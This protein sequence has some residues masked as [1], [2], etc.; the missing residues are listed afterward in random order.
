[1]L[2]TTLLLLDQEGVVALATYVLVAALTIGLIHWLRVLI[3]RLEAA[4]NR[5]QLLVSELQHRS[6]NLFTVIQSIA[7]RSLVDGQPL[8][9]AREVF[10]SRLHALARAHRMLAEAAWT[11]A[12]LVQIL[13]EELASVSNSVTVNGC[14]IVINTPAA[15]H[16]AMIVHELATNALKYGALSLPGGRIRIEGSTEQINGAPVL[17]PSRKGFGT[18]I[19]IDAAKQVAQNVSVNYDPNGLR[20]ELQVLL[21]TIQVSPSPSAEHAMGRAAVFAALH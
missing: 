1:L 15:Q 18:A 2:P 12:P 21:R 8:S 7:S 20:Y 13:K 14:D 4:Q 3:D 19:L 17:V 9:A 16:F 10:A 5:Q 6:Q 11:G